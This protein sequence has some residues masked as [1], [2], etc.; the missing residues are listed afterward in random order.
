MRSNTKQIWK[1]R[2]TKHILRLNRSQVFQVKIWSNHMLCLHL[3]KELWE[4]LRF[5]RQTSLSQLIAWK[6][7]RACVFNSWSENVCHLLNILSSAKTK[8]HPEK[9]QIYHKN[10]KKKKLIKYKRTKNHR[11]IHQK[12][13]FLTQG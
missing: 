5:V 8:G 12:I 9:Y 10:I 6:S 1:L 3:L 4:S 2:Q 11:K 7:A 13:W